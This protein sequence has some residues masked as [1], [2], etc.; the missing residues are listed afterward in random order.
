MQLSESIPE[1]Y[2][3]IINDARKGSIIIIDNVLWKG[4]VINKNKKGISEVMHSLNEH[5]F[6]D[7][8]VESFILPVRDG[9]N[10]LKVL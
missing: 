3:H 10:I 5:I 2:D 8:R 7:T 1:Y 6:N 4:T 9:L